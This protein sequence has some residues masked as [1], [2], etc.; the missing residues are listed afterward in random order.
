[1]DGWQDWDT[2]AKRLKGARKAR[3]LTQTQL[4]EASGVSQSDLSKLERGDSATSTRWPHL[5]RALRVDAYWLASGEGQPEPA[6]GSLAFEDIQ[7]PTIDHAV[8]VLAE[9]LMTM[10]P[11]WREAASAVLANLGRHP[12]QAE[13]VL[14]SLQ[15]MIRS[16]PVPPPIKPTPSPTKPSR[17]KQ[18]AKQRPP[19]KAKL[20]LKMGGGDKRQLALPLRTVRNP[21]DQSAAPENERAWYERLKVT[22]KASS[23]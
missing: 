10:E 20:V 19:G 12:E 22:P 1:M 16:Q 14:A 17:A 4:T 18:H 8:H 5:A 23:R 3:G 7:P 21:F 11:T 13:T 2:P 9:A 6:Q 15:V